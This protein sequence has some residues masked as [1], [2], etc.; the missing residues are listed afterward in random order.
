MNRSNHPSSLLS[1]L[2]RMTRMGLMALLFCTIA[3]TVYGQSAESSGGMQTL[4]DFNRQART[5][6]WSIYA[7]GGL[8]WASGVWYQNID[9][10]RSYKQSPAVGGGI[11][12][13]IA[14]WVRVGAE[15]LWSRYRREQRFSTI[16]AS[17]M[18]VKTYGNYMMN[19]HKVRL[20]A[21]FNLMELWPHRTAQWFNVYAGTGVGYLFAKGNEYGIWFN[22]TLSQGGT[23]TPLAPGTPINNNGSAILTGN[24]RTTNEHSNFR[25]FYIPASLH[26]E[27]NLSPS[28]AVGVKGEV[29]WLVSRK[30]MAPKNVIFALATLRYSFVPS[31]VKALTVRY[32]GEIGWLNDRLNALHQQAEAD[33][34]R[35][36]RAESQQQEL[37]KRLQE[38]EQS[39]SVVQQPEFGVLSPYFVQFAHNSSYI[40]RTE[41]ERLR[42]FAQS[43]KGRSLNLVAEA[44]TPGETD[45]NQQLSERRLQRVVDFLISEGFDRSSLHPTIAIGEQNGKPTAEGRRVTI[46]VE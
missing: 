32:E 9:A 2:G 10:R 44:S 42:I 46:T 41:A 31:R 5:R 43:A 28:I 18:P 45:Y 13:H 23:T 12:Y 35:A 6:T 11:D 20:G 16:E 24:V 26:I 7:Q 30:D 22:N 17:Q 38:C 14:P 1:F 34:L 15:Y 3:T 19:Y 36:D 39:W 8:S 33:R 21:D 40:N 27:A 25:N 29:D 37:N 4:P